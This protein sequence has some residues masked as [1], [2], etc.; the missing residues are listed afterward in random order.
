MGQN[1]NEI[2]VHKKRYYMVHAEVEFVDRW[3]QEWIT[4]YQD[5]VGV[6]SAPASWLDHSK[7]FQGCLIGVE[8]RGIG[9]FRR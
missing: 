5:T 6:S 9:L 4:E 3:Q 7:A 1:R 2:L 8:G